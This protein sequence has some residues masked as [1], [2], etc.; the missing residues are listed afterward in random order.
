MLGSARTLRWDWISAEQ[1][2][3]T[4]GRVELPAH[5]YFDISW[6]SSLPGNLLAD[7]HPY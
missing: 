7:R 1:L 3:T 5:R 6:L 4:P 2:R